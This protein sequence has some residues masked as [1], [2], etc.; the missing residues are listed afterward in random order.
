M[1]S[2]VEENVSVSTV[3]I[4]ETNGRQRRKRTRRRRKKKKSSE[5]DEQKDRTDEVELHIDPPPD[6]HVQKCED[7]TQMQKNRKEEETQ[8]DT[9]ET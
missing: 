9:K 6:V 2:T 7:V 3:T 8:R 1:S 4:N 5:D